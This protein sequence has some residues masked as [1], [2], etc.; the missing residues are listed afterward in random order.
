MKFAETY[1]QLFVTQ[2][3]FQENMYCN[4]DEGKCL[5]NYIISL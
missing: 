5:A 4:P 3:V 2:I 1:R